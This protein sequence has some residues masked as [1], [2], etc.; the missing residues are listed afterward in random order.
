MCTS[1]YCFESNGILVIEGCVLLTR[2]ELL[3]LVDAYNEGE[4]SFAEWRMF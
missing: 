4:F 1:L 2:E 3:N